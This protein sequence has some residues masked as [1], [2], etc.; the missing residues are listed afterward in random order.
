[1]FC[2][3][4]IVNEFVKQIADIL[5]AGAGFGVALEAEH[6][7][8]GQLDALQGIVKQGFVGNPCVGG[9]G[10]GIDGEAVVLAGDD[11]FAAVQ[12]LHGV[13]CAVVAEVHFQSFCTD[14]EADELVSQTDAED[15]FAA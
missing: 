15:G 5:R 10:V 12:I 9:Q 2:R 6:G 11:D 4:H 14:G 13:V 7:F 8:V 3:F 1:M